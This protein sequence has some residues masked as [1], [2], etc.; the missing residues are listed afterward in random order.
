MFIGILFEMAGIGVLIP[1]LSLLLNP[2][3]GQKYPSLQP[4]LH[5]LG[6][7]SAFELTFWVMVFLV[8]FYLIKSVF[9]GYLGW[10][11]SK[12]IAHLSLNLVQDLFNGYINQP[13]IFHL[14]RNSTQLIRNLQTEIGQF[15][16]LSQAVLLLVL[17]LSATIGIAILLIISEPVGA[18]SVILFLLISVF[19]FQRLTRKKLLRWGKVRQDQ[20]ELINKHLFQGLGGVKDVKFSGKEKYF[21]DLLY[22]HNYE[23]S[24]ITI[25]YF[26]IGLLPRLFLEFFAVLAI[27]GI[28]I[29]MILQNK[30][31][32]HFIPALGLFGAAAFRLIPSGNRV[33]NSIQSIRFLEPVVDVLFN[34]FSLIQRAANHLQSKGKLTFTQNISLKDVD[35]SYPGTQLRTLDKINISIKKGETVGFMGPSGSGKS[36]LIDVI[37]GLLAPQSGDIF[38]DGESIVKNLRIWQDHIGYVPQSV[39]LTDDTIRRN[40][41]FGI[42]DEKIDNDE[43]DRSIRAAQLDEFVENLPIGLDTIVGERGVRLSGGQ[44]Q[45]IGIARALYHNPEILILDEATSSL[46]TLNETGV[47]QAVCHLQGE[48]TI[49]IVAHRLSTLNICD[50]I[51]KLSNG[52]IVQEGIPEEILNSHN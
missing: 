51:Y 1:V 21:T 2:D 19:V 6:N 39:Y 32:D 29:V 40:V 8:L 4:F 18:I 36:T 13:Y 26:T 43:V 16:I 25:R 44:R 11:Q 20:A 10:M 28:I 48:K 42:V 30:P 33:M 52:K 35:F 41:A 47:M 37:L 7:P 3:I 15:T 12:F 17:E 49:I 38:V 34:E 14:Q 27:T 9:L 5:A 24:K 46:D 22:E 23:H 45:R 31:M 50:R